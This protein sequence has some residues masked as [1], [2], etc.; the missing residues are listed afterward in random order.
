MKRSRLAGRRKQSGYE[1]KW[2]YEDQFCRPICRRQGTGA[3]TTEK[4][5]QVTCKLCLKV[6]REEGI[7]K[8]EA[9]DTI[10]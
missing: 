4:V 9:T 1:S 3:L 7:L 10:S 2:H 8:N 6:M 5:E